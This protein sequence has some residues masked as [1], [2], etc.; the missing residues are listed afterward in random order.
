[1]T[2]KNIDVTIKEGNTYFDTT[3]DVTSNNDAKR[4]YAAYAEKMQK[5][6]GKEGEQ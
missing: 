2:R 3:L 1:M 4:R 6:V 5:S